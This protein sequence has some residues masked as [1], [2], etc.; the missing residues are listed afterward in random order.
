MLASSGGQLLSKSPSVNCKNQI[1][2]IRQRVNPWSVFREHYFINLHD[3]LYYYFLTYYTML[4]LKKHGL[5]VD[6]P[7]TS[8]KAQICPSSKQAAPI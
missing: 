4:R 5:A 1:T 6:P 2:V 3:R 8:F 7:K